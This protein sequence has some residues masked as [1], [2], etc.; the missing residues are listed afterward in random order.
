[1]NMES[2]L[3]PALAIAVAM[4]CVLAVFSCSEQV[5]SNQDGGFDAALRRCGPNIW[6]CGDGGTCVDGYCVTLPGPCSKSSDCDGGEC[7]GGKCVAPES[8]GGDLDIVVEDGGYC[9]TSENCDKGYG[10]NENHNC[11][12][13][14]IIS[15]SPPEEVDFGAVS[16][17]FENVRTLTVTNIGK[18]PLYL[19]GFEIQNP[20]ANACFR[21]VSGGALGTLGENE[22]RVVEL[23]Y[24]Q[25]NAEAVTGTLRIGSTDQKKGI[26]PV[27]L[28]SSFKG[29]PAFM[30][31]DESG[32]TL[33]YPKAGAGYELP[34]DF[35]LVPTGT[36][37]HLAW[38]VT[39]MTAGNAILELSKL[40]QIS[41]GTN[42]VTLKI[43][44]G[45]AEDS[46]DL[47]PPVYI[48]AAETVYL[49]AYYDSQQSVE[50]DRV[51]FNLTTN[52][53]DINKSGNP[54]FNSV[55]LQ[56]S[57]MSKASKIDVSPLTIN[58]G[59]VQ[60]GATLTLPLTIAN[61]GDL[62]LN[63]YA[64]SGLRNGTTWYSIQP[65]V[66]ART[67]KPEDPPFV[68]QVTFSP[69]DAYAETN[70]IDLNSDDPAKPHVEVALDGVGV[71][72]VLDVATDPLPGGTPPTMDLGVVVN[73]STLTGKVTVKNT[74][75][76]GQLYLESVTVYQGAASVYAITNMKLNDKAQE[77]PIYLKP[78]SEDILIFDIE[79]NSA[80][81]GTFTG[82]MVFRNS[83]I[84]HKDFTVGMTARSGQADG[85][86]CT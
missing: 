81:S 67:I 37:R 68:I 65:D 60:K 71:D 22:F 80:A 43:R 34:L 15:V 27:N 20:P 19:T 4:G 33:V 2:R 46:G 41:S 24:R 25:N 39:N 35:G 85:T 29:S 8:D 36:I 82:S 7:R 83:D 51:N 69:T 3:F 9:E 23:G 30:V 45:A 38:A 47:E 57:A 40:E 42:T 31:Y 79:F 12:A 74:G 73:G 61:M 11:V 53:N 56:F 6:E 70:F 16:F 76:S 64:T 66:L 52:D 50:L 75:L 18:L 77:L 72:P 58:F 59:E 17:G 14:A 10:C 55:V 48:G 86:D 62:D 63:I 26:Y 28:K 78:D 32:T 54:G 49:H 1:M 5:V 84:N 44:K 21:I 13:A